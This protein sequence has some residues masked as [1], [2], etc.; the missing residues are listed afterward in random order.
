MLFPPSRKYIAALV[1]IEVG[2]AGLAGCRTV[3]PTPEDKTP[4]PSESPI[5]QVSPTATQTPEP[6]ALIVNGEGVSLAEYDAQLKQLQ[7]ADTDLGKTQTPEEQRKMVLAE[8]TDQTL[9]AQAAVLDGFSLDDAGLQ[10]KVDKLAAD[11]GGQPAL[12]SWMTANGY[13]SASFRTA[14]RRAAGSAWER[15]KIIAAVPDKAEQVKL[16]QILVRS[17]DT[18]ESVYRQLQAGAVFATLAA[19]Y[20]PITSGIL[21]WIPRGYLTQPAVEEAAFALQPGQYSPV[22]Q[23]SFGYHIVYVIERE[24]D[25]VMSTDARQLLQHKA[26]ENWLIE[27]RASAAVTVQLP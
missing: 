1:L 27:K 13:T 12:D 17:S 15:E 21:G 5:P 11:L 6:L 23:T 26:L 19:N 20:D 10:A 7:A 24:S 3:T 2:L 4:L 22:I 14:I 25:R 9:L 8:L 18:A 16:Q